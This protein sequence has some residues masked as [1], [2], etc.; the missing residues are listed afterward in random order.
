LEQVSELVLESIR[1]GHNDYVGY[2]VKFGD[3]MFKDAAVIAIENNY[4]EILKSI[5]SL[6]DEKNN[7]YFLAI[8]MLDA[9]GYEDF[10]FSEE[11]M[12]YRHQDAIE[13]LAKA[14]KLD[15]QQRRRLEIERIVENFAYFEEV[16]FTTP[17]DI[18]ANRYYGSKINSGHVPY[19]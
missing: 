13:D 4:P 17:K 18:D 8:N 5:L 10:T 7:K 11:E 16:Y 12:E 19:G 15:D 9:L 14:K 3:D 1:N 2:L 6:T